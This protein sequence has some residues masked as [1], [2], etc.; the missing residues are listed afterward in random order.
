M[1]SGN[2]KDIKRRI[3]SVESTMQIT[4]A[5]ELVASSKLRKAKEK[6]DNA[7]PYFN[8]LYETMCEI[9][10]ENPGFFSQY[11]K[12]RDAKT[13]LLVVIAGD[14]GLAGGF[15]SNI[16]KLAQARIDELKGSAEVKVIAIGKK[17]AEYFIKRGY[18]LMGSYP[19]IAEGLK[20]HHAADISDIIMQKFV[21]GEIDKVELFHTE[22]VSPLLQ[23]AEALSVLPMDVHS[24]DDQ[25]SGERS[26]IKELPVYE[27]SPETVFDAIVPKYITGMIFCAV[28]DSFASEQ[29]SRRIAME[30]ASDNA[31]EMIS[32]LSLMYNRA[33]QASITQEITEIVGGA[34]AQE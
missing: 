25:G 18:D 5:M 33:R 32:G 17:S 4:K 11:T 26:R 19:N 10:S 24:G 9:Q 12:K 15:N 13:V 29:A 34:A 7:R 16:L 14:R 2:M 30:N 28:V 27:P 31:G 6:A 1:A 3:K 8:A 21:S 23:Q 22:Y 20:I